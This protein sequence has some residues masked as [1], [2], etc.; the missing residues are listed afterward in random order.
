MQGYLESKSGRSFDVEEVLDN[1]RTAIGKGM[2]KVMA[3]MGISTLHSYKGSQIFEAVGLSPEIIQKCFPQ[4]PSR[5]GG[6]TFSAL[7]SDLMK[8]HERGFNGTKAYLQSLGSWVSSQRSNLA[9]GPQ[10][11]L[12]APPRPDVPQLPSWGELSY[13]Q[14]KEEHLNTPKSISK[15]QAATKNRS[16][17]AFQEYVD[18]INQQNSKCTIRGVLKFKPSTSSISLDEVVSGPTHPVHWISD[19]SVL[20]EPASEIM[21]RF[22]TGAMSLGSI[23]KE[24]HESLAEAMNEIGGRSNTGEGGEDPAR[25]TP[26]DNGRSRN[27]KIKQIASGRFGVTSHY[28]ANAQEIQIKMAQGAKP[29]EG[30]ELPGHKVVQ[31]IAKTRHTTPGVGLI[32][33]PPHHDIYSIGMFSLSFKLTFA[34]HCWSLR[35]QR[36]LHSSFMTS[37][38]PTLLLRSVSNWFLK[39]ALAP[40]LPEFLRLVQIKSPSPAMMEA[41]GLPRGQASVMLACLGNLEC[42][43]PNKLWR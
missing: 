25:F 30:G 16:R 24:A 32:S 37:R 4:M 15:L 17:E 6:A 8:L 33:P 3:K 18:A 36:I 22:V 34:H 10:Q 28:L 14:G 20:Q 12:S 29:G 43:K 19:S 39:W 27:S 26:L 42:L 23:S 38:M 35:I 31:M 1:Y 11:F 41:Q 21:K 13:R 7:Q 2:L 40:L 9:D 5:I